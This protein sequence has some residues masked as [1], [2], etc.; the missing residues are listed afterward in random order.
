MTLINKEDKRVK[1]IVPK[2]KI[3]IKKRYA[4]VVDIFDVFR[5]DEWD[6]VEDEE[7]S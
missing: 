7:N 3:T 1:V 2:D 5:F 4:R 6:L